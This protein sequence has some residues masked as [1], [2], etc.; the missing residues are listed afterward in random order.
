MAKATKVT[1]DQL[2][3]VVTIEEKQ[4]S[5]EVL[6]LRKLLQIQDEGCWGKHLH[7][8]INERINKLNAK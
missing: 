6:F 2:P 7:E 4:E 3:K 1:E 5:E 8:I